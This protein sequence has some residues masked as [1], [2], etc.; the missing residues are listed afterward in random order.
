MA[1]W[2]R[3]PPLHLHAATAAQATITTGTI[4]T[5]RQ[6]NGWTAPTVNVQVQLQAGAVLAVV[7]TARGQTVTA[8]AA[9]AAL[10]VRMNNSR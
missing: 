1:N 4:G 8:A 6:L 10:Y 5:A 2:L 3:C 9:A 7:A